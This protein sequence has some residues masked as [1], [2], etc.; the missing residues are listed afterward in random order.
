MVE[1]YEEIFN[2]AESPLSLNESVAFS[3]LR[4]IN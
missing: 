2:T 3:S 4:C 1:M